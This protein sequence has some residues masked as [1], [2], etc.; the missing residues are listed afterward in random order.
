MNRFGGL[1]C[2]AISLALVSTFL[3]TATAGELLPPGF[4]PLPPGAHALVGGKVVVKPGESLE[5]GTIV[6]RDGL[7]QAV[8][9]NVTVP[10]DARV[11]DM[12]GAVIYAGFIEPY[13]ALNSTNP[14]VATSDTEPISSSSF[15]AG[16]VKF[17]GAP[18]AKTDMGNAGPGDEMN[19]VMPEFRA[20]E[21]Y[22][23]DTKVLSPLREIGFTSAVIAPGR[24]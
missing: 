14:P 11:W 1:F 9:T 10:A 23:P 2:S 5:P 16:G 15:T 24:G 18:G 3:F 12:K 4:R 6:I 13:F 8:G 20:I 17:F 21:K 22:S 7:I 19:K